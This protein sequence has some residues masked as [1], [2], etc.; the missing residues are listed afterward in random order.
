MLRTILTLA[1]GLGCAAALAAGGAFAQSPPLLASFSV[2]SGVLPY[3]EQDALTGGEA[4]TMSIELFA[5]RADPDVVLSWR[6]A[7]ARSGVV[8][9]V[10]RDG[11]TL[12]KYYLESAWPSKVEISGL[13][14]GSSEVL[15]ETV[16]I[17]ATGVR[18]VS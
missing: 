6:A 15:M 17:V 14:A 8:A 3:I 7:G 4:K 10:D 16:T 1:A 11:R 9:F 13:K 18:R 5:L 12:G 2:G